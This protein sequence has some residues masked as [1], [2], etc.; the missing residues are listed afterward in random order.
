MHHSDRIATRG[1]MYT[2]VRAVA[3]IC[4]AVHWR[5]RSKYAQSKI[6]ALC[7]PCKACSARG[8]SHSAHAEPERRAHNS[9]CEHVGAP[10]SGPQNAIPMG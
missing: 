5:L 8:K 1:Y 10:L 6:P 7:C 3:E 4:A 2:G 9:E